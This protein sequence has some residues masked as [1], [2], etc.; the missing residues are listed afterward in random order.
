M[1][2]VFMYKTKGDTKTRKEW[3]G[4]LLVMAGRKPGRGTD[5]VF[6]AAFVIAMHS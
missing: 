3:F 1:S 2:F 5:T 6:K 4:S